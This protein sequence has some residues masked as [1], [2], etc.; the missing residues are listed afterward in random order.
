MKTVKFIL[1]IL[2]GLAFGVWALFR[3]DYSRMWESLEGANYVYLLPMIAF[4]FF[5]HWLRV[6]RWRIFLEPISRFRL[7]N[8]F[9]ALMIGYT[10]NTVMPAHLG[11]FVRAFAAGKLGKVPGARIFS[12]IVVERILDMVTFLLLTAL[13]VL[14][15]PFPAWV[16][17]GGYFILLFVLVLVAGLFLLKIRASGTLHFLNKI[18]IIFPKNIREKFV[19]LTEDFLEGFNG[20]KNYIQY[21]QVFFYSLL[22]WIAYIV[23]FWLGFEM[24]HLQNYRLTWLSALVLVVITTIG[25]IVPNSPG[26]V[27]TYH[28]L[29]QLGLGLF[30]VSA[31]EG[32]S[33]AIVLH[34]VNFLPV[35]L[36]GLFLMALKG[37]SLSKISGQIEKKGESPPEIR[38][39]AQ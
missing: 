5:S 11:E 24:F 2:I 33:F 22:I 36:L 26:Y 8:L 32:M 28:K 30:G 15:F 25:V 16:V 19:A 4:L 13:A 39:S 38:Q 37:W 21:I 14:L 20:L 27:G 9:T 1:S 12:S 10:A 31:S 23:I 35:M 34:A 7:K 17:H 6:L 29:C 18:S 3:V